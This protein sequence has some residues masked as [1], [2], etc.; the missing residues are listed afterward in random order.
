M[1]RQVTAKGV[2]SFSYFFYFL[3]FRS[4]TPQE[5]EILNSS[6]TLCQNPSSEKDQE[7][8]AV[9]EEPKRPD[10]NEV[11]SFSSFS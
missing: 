3:F 7:S 11:F 10:K 1:K 4:D 9:L 6:E 8:A 2:F 5:N